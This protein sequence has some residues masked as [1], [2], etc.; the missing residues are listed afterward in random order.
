MQIDAFDR[1]AI[2][3]G[4]RG[5]NRRSR[6]IVLKGQDNCQ[7]HISFLFP[8]GRSVAIVIVV[9]RMLVGIMLVVDV[10]LVL[11][12]T[13]VEVKVEEVGAR[14]TVPMP[15]AG[16]L[17]PETTDEDGRDRADDRARL[18]GISDQGPS[19]V[20]HCLIITERNRWTWNLFDD[21]V[22]LRTYARLQVDGSVAKGDSLLEAEIGEFGNSV[23]L[24]RFSR[25][26]AP[27]TD[28]CSG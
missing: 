15:V 2:G 5:R 8:V 17:Q 20:L 18:P 6:R 26:V 16:S 4:L 3:S 25:T 22:T 7:N 9:S 12:V 21:R 24:R 28:V 19:E 11:V 13:D 14:L 1:S 10:M 27:S 23:D